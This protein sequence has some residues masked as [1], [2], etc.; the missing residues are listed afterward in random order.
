MRTNDLVAEGFLAVAAA[1]FMLL[2]SSLL[3]FAFS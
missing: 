2:C 1:G 3:A